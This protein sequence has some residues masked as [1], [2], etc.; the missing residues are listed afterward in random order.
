MLPGAVSRPSRWA[1]SRSWTPP[2]PPAAA[3]VAG[4][5]VAVAVLT[6]VT[7][8]VPVWAW[9]AVRD[10]PDG[11]RLREATVTGRGSASVTTPTRRAGTILRFRL[12]DG[13]RGRVYVGDRWFVPDEGD[14]IE[15]Y[16]GDGGWES[17]ERRSSGSLVGGLACLVLW[18]SLT[19]GW[20]RAVRRGRG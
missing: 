15:V 4:A 12:H 6:V 10:V 14:T 2:P 18:P 5:I 13:G 17:P 16:R 20:L 1:A 9:F 3:P 8:V 11:V 19:A 7:G